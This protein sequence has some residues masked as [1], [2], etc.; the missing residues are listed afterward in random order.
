[1]Q[2]TGQSWGC[3]AH[4]E[5]S[6]GYVLAKFPFA[7]PVPWVTKQSRLTWGQIATFYIVMTSD[8]GS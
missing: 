7:K 2:V 5:G 1:M 6:P 8:A 4:P 3:P